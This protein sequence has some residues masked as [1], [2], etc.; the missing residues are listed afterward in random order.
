MAVTSHLKRTKLT[1][2][3][4]AYHTG[5]KRRSKT[6]TYLEAGS[7]INTRWWKRERPTRLPAFTCNHASIS[8]KA[9]NQDHVDREDTYHH[10]PRGPAHTKWGTSAQPLRSTKYMYHKNKGSTAG[11]VEATSS[12]HSYWRA[13]VKHQTGAQR[14]R[15][16]EGCCIYTPFPLQWVA[17]ISVQLVTRIQM[18][19]AATIT[20][21]WNYKN[22]EN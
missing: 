20:Q 2:L 1:L 3:K 9:I 13:E 18:H 21:R 5:F 8:F 16:G 19:Y 12:V 6:T 22:Q 15:A 11:Q 10:N 14:E 17:T 4:W 7:D